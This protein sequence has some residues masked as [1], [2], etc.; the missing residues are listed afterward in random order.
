LDPQNPR[1]TKRQSRSLAV[2]CLDFRT[3]WKD[4]DSRLS[5]FGVVLK[6]RG[7][8]EGIAHERAVAMFIIS[9]G[10]FVRGEMDIPKSVTKQPPTIVLLPNERA[11]IVHIHVFGAVAIRVYFCE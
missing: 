6:G 4:S 11:R 8:S 2:F 9:Q 5:K 7:L 1:L 3:I 10:Q